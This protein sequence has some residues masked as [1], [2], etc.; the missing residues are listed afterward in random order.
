M[1]ILETPDL[2]TKSLS[3]YPNPVKIILELNADTIISSVR[4]YDL[5]G[6]EVHSTKVNDM[7]ASVDMSHYV[8]GIYFVK[9]SIDGAEEILKIIKQ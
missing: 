9:V 2:T 1:V 8:S 5:T 7:S 4:I 3:A 6:K